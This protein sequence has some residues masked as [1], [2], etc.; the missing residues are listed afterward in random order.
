LVAVASTAEWTNLTDIRKTYPATDMVGDLAIFNI[1]AT[2]TGWWFGW[3][4]APSEST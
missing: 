1:R 4:F 3:L 2:I